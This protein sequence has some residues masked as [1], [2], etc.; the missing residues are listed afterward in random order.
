MNLKDNKGQRPR[1]PGNHFKP[2]LK[3]KETFTKQRSMSTFEDGF[4]LLFQSLLFVPTQ[5][6]ISPQRPDK[7]RVQLVDPKHTNQ[8][9]ALEKVVAFMH[10]LNEIVLAGNRLHQISGFKESI[11]SGASND[12]AM[13][14]ISYC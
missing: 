8:V 10:E 6:L 13:I 5:N 14:A 9:F 2:F 7:R 1:V 12:S 4:V 11:F 3:P